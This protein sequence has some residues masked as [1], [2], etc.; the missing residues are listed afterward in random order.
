MNVIVNCW[1]KKFNWEAAI[2]AAIIL[3]LALPKFLGKLLGFSAGDF[4]VAKMSGTVKSTITDLNRMRKAKKQDMK[5]KRVVK[6]R[7][8]KRR[9]GDDDGAYMAT[10]GAGVG[11]SAAAQRKKEE[12]GDDAVADVDDD[13][14]DDGGGDGGD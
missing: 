3:L 10:A 11:L 1:R 8:V 9:D 6:R 5:V 4:N 13:G 2:G 12:E 7:V 14:G